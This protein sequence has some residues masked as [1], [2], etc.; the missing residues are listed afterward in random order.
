MIP[1][2]VYWTN[3]NTMCFQLECLCPGVH[4][5]DEGEREMRGHGSEYVTML[6][7]VRAAPDAETFCKQVDF[8]QVSAE[9]MFVK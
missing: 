5:I 1:N 3:T 9:F 2:Q 6:L 7:H 8:F 4:E